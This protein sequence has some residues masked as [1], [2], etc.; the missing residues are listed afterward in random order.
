MRKHVIFWSMIVT[1]ILTLITGFVLWLA[2]KGSHSRE[3][4]IYGLQK[5]TW[6]DI[7]P[8]IA[9]SAILLV[10]IHLIDRRVCLRLYLRNPLN[11]KRD[12]CEI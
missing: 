10:G 12:R 11:G 1:G 5:S 6:L 2:P 7:H 8:W 3:A 4:V 9:I